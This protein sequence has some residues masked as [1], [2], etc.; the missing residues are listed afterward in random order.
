M[1]SNET[2]V[3]LD[4]DAL[5]A[6]GRP[7]PRPPFTARLG[8]NVYTF[9]DAMELDWQQI[10]SALQD[11]ALFF[12][13]TLGA[14]ADAFLNHRLSVRS[15]RALMDRYREHYGMTGPGEAVALPR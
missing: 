8:G 14:D 13:L 2:T 7:D 10:L 1:T 5:E 4:L 3:A 15:L 9:A 12:R 6:E 11:P